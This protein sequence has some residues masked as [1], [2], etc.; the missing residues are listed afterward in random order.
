MLLKIALVLLAAWL[1]GILGVF[2]VGNPV[3]VLL[4]VGLMLLLLGL[5]RARDAAI[6]GAPR[7]R[8][9]VQDGAGGISSRREES[10]LMVLR[11]L[12]HLILRT[13]AEHGRDAQR[14]AR[15]AV[16]LLACAPGFTL[17]AVL[18][19]AMGTGLTAAMYAQVQSTVLADLPGAVR[20]PDDLIRLDRPVSGP[21]CEDLREGTTAF[22]Q[23]AGYIGR[24]P[25]TLELEDREHRSRVWSQLVTPN[26]FEVLGIQAATG[27]LFGREEQV[28]GAMSV[29]L[30]D[31]L[32]RTRF[33]AN[34]AIVGQ[35]IRVNGQLVTIIGVAAP[36]FAGASPMTAAAE[37]WIPTTAS[38]RLAPELSAWRNRQV[39]NVE[40]VGR[41]ESDTPIDR[42]EVALQTVYGRLGQMH[43]DPGRAANE[44]PMRVMPGGRMFP[45]RNEDL[46]RAIGFP[47]VLVSL[48]LLMACGNV[49]NLTLARGVARHREFALRLALGAGRSRVVR[50]LITENV[51]LSAVGSVAGAVV[52]VW[53][54]SLFERMRPV[55]P[56]YVHYDVQFH[57]PAY[58]A[59][60]AVA[61]LSTVFFGLAPSLR[62]SRLDIHA[63]L[64]PN[65]G[66]DLKGRR[67][68]GLR[69]LVIYQQVAVSV[70]LILLTGFVVVGWRRAAAVDLGFDAAQLYFLSVDPI[71]DGFTPE[72]TEQLIDMLQ[73]R[74]RTTP[75]IASVSMAQTI[76]LAMSSADLLISARTDLAAGTKSLGT[77]RVDR[78]GAGFFDTTGTALVRGR[79]FSRT[80]H[81]ND[82]RVIVVNETMARRAWPDADAVGQPLTLGTDTWE[83]I[84]VVS[85]TRS[86]F[87]LAPTLPAVY[88]PVTPAGYASPSSNGVTVVVRTSENIDISARL[89]SEV[90]AIAPELTVVEIKPLTREVDQAL[91]LARVATYTYG[92]IGVLALILAAAGLAGVTA[93]AVARRTKEIGIRMALGAQRSDVL[94]LVLR[95]GTGIIVAGTA[96]GLVLAL[97]LTRALSGVV[98]A[99]AETTQTSVS[100]P[101]LLLGGPALLMALA[102]IACYVPAR[103]STQI[104]PITALRSE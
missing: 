73:E 96:T 62:A 25:V 83:V 22:A 10:A 55:L 53:L 45:V 9:D 34:A 5:L 95:E 18:C 29:V 60:A 56:A 26:Y 15:H 51:L 37:L 30:G 4:L 72:R 49:A 32:W 67:L 78:V 98:E 38:P 28:E 101:V 31:R 19:L 12:P 66:S 63:G 71:R 36:G 58:L 89:M 46:P 54:L 64:K 47:L 77:L 39:S 17:A 75:G 40:I 8:A 43:G 50:Q 61:T 41:L 11:R 94:W 59:A 27:H 79:T 100:D 87:P 33:G 97:A 52:A 65:S 99:L 103:R 84:G 1:V 82:S 86:A 102:M 44:P 80:D 85:D 90:R 93:Y 57:W 48:V 23:L 92:G 21:D 16:K 24:V 20:E 3:H 81:S 42:A 35:P 70:V 6:T 14:D 76:P 68:F 2:S 88:R 13:A 69:N 104:D 7:R 91:F 74:L